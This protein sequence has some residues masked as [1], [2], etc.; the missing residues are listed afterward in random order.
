METHAHPFAEDS[1]HAIELK[2]EGGS[3]FSRTLI[4]RAQSYRRLGKWEWARRDLE[5][6][7]QAEP[8][9]AI[10]HLALAEL[11]LEMGEPEKSFAAALVYG[12]LR[13]ND[14]HGWVARARASR[15][16]GDYLAADHA[17]SKAIQNSTFLRPELFL[18]RVA[19]L[20][21]STWSPLLVHRRIMRV[22]DEGI[23]CL[24]NLVSLQSEAIRRERGSGNHEGALKRVDLLLSAQRSPI[25][26]YK[27]RGDILQDARRYH[28]AYHDYQCALCA[29]DAL[30]AKRRNLRPFRQLREEIVASSIRVPRDCCP[31][32]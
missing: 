22:L 32:P 27:I 13:P 14:A 1:L 12:N 5:K 25:K 31:V 11:L 28:E 8:R 19:A 7:L 6:A 30:P 21:A 4:K 10:A 26:W 2:S 9:L 23:S 18:E 20:D 3:E 16:C 17:Y 29:L 24:G 15:A